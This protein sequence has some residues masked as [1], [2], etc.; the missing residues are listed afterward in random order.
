MCFGL[1]NRFLWQTRKF[2]NLLLSLLLVSIQ[3]CV[4][5]V[6]ERRDTHTQTGC[7]IVAMVE[8]IPHLC[9]WNFVTRKTQVIAH[10]M[11]FIQ[12]RS[13]VTIPLL[14]HSTADWRNTT[15]QIS[16]KISIC[17]FHKRNSHLSSDF[18]FPPM[19]VHLKGQW[20]CTI[21]TAVAKWMDKDWKE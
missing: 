20:K 8:V 3:L 5:C 18:Y 2:F 17:K 19:I 9:V 7:V 12:S 14:Q 13:S 6:G 1:V 16:A 15:E 11:L 21:F 4:L 10:E